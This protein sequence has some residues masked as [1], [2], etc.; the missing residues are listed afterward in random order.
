MS[1]GRCWSS[2]TYNPVPGVMEGVP[3]ANNY[4]GGFGTTLMAKVQDLLLPVL[5]SSRPLMLTLSNITI[6]WVCTSNY[7]LFSLHK[8]TEIQWSWSKFLLTTPTP[9]L[10]FLIHCVCLSLSPLGRLLCFTSQLLFCL[11]VV[12]L[13]QSICDSLCPSWFYCPC[14][15]S[16]LMVSLC[17]IQCIWMSVKSLTLS[18]CGA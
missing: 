11:S 13:H 14:I 2:D 17:V 8:M 7:L 5:S 3:S 1:S 16:S 4:Q 15:S 6:C 10:C 12:L 18:I 9:F